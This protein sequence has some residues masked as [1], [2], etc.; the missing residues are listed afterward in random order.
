MGTNMAIM[1]IKANIYTQRKED[2]QTKIFRR[3]MLPCKE[4][5]GI[6]FQKNWLTDISIVKVKDKIGSA[7]L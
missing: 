5:Q 7:D 6:R 4:C 1:Y 3:A 2:S